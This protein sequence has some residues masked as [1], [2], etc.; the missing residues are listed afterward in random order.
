MLQA[1]VNN[2]GEG[3]L[4]QQQAIALYGNGAILLFLATKVQQL[5]VVPL[6]HQDRQELRHMLHLLIS[7]A[8]GELSDQSS[9]TCWLYR[10]SL[11]VRMPV[12][13]QTIQHSNN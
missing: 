4:Q 11:L 10:H 12:C 8:G 7:V 13:C 5:C 3:Q 2:V 9:H 1:L 6:S